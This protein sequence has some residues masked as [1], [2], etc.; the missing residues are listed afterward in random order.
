MTY[1]HSQ[2]WI[3][4][5]TVS[6][7]FPWLRSWLFLKTYDSTTSNMTPHRFPHLPCRLSTQKGTVPIGLSLE[8]VLAAIPEN[9]KM[10]FSMHEKRFFWWMELNGN[11]IFYEFLLMSL[12]CIAFFWNVLISWEDIWNIIKYIV[13]RHSLVFEGS[14]FL[15]VD[16]DHQPSDKKFC[17][18]SVRF[19]NLS[20]QVKT[21]YTKC[22]LYTN[23]LNQYGSL[24]VGKRLLLQTIDLLN[25]K[26]NM[27]MKNIWWSPVWTFQELLQSSNHWVT[28]ILLGDWIQPNRCPKDPL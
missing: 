4:V 24:Q 19:A 17:N 26:Q 28:S 9:E 6:L 15:V 14:H 27:F 5:T 13:F 22:S 25:A 10:G 11:G 1:N 2:I 12:C 21:N 23:I 20:L 8:R 16:S 3:V 18:R 7:T